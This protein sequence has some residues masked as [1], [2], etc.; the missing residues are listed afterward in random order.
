MGKLRRTSHAVYEL[1][2]HIVWAPKYR[3]RVLTGEVRKRVL[4]LF[5]RIAEEYGFEIIEQ[6]VIDDH[7]HVFVSAPPRISPSDVVKTLKSISGRELFR[8]F[9]ELRKRFWKRELWEDGYFM[10]AVGD[11]LTTDEIRAYVRHQ[12]KEKKRGVQ[13]S[14]FGRKTDK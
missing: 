4:D 14:L 8:E 7:V 9:S 13:L 6:E 3:R 1:N 10:R 2:Y 5:A 12:E 11:K